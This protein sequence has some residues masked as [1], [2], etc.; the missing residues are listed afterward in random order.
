MK[1]YGIREFFLNG[2]E[3][4]QQTFGGWLMSVSSLEEELPIDI[5]LEGLV[6]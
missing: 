2:Q 5:F 1:N 6:C 3:D 4:G